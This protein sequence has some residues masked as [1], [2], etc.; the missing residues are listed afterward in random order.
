MRNIKI[1]GLSLTHTINSIFCIGRNYADHAK[2]L[3]NPVP[4]LPVVFTKPVNTVT[5]DGGEI[6]IPTNLTQD[7]HHEAE[8]VI[9]IG[10]FGR[11]ISEAEAMDYVSGYAIGI[12]VT[13]RD[14]Q[15]ALK[16][17]SQ[18]WTLAKGM[19]TFAPIGSFVPAAEVSDPHNLNVKL[20]V[21]GQTRQ[22]GNTSDMI[23][24]IPALISYV[25][26]FI[27]LHEGDLIFT[28]TP[29]GVGPLKNGDKV[30]AT[31]GNNLSRLSVSVKEI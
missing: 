31:L 15:A 29:A 1:P 6:I 8:M 18:P 7:V 30:V 12:D 14:L 11:Y 27:T 10:K 19:D 25:S 3:N 22:D 5:F 16:E 21:N 9:S 2:E 28:G 26:R 20:T 13:A 4:A 23:F 17:K 24:S